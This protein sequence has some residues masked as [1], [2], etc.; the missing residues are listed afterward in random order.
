MK[1]NISL[2]MYGGKLRMKFSNDLLILKV[3]VEIKKYSNF[4]QFFTLSKL[5]FIIWLVF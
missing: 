2:P 5:C 4:I 3:F 1:E